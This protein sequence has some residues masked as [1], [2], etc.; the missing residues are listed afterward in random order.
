MKRRMVVLLGVFLMNAAQA[1]VVSIVAAEN[2]YG[3]VAQKLGGPYVQVT[4]ILSNP[5]QDP[6]LFSANPQTAKAIAQA[7]FIVYNGLDYDSWI[8]PLA[9]NSQNNHARLINVAD[10]NQKKTGENPHI[11]YNPKIMAVFADDLSRQLSTSD[12]AH[13][14][15]YQNQLH[16]FVQNYQ[17]LMDRIQM[18]K[19]KYQGISII[20]TE[21]VFNE[22][23]QLMGLQM[24]GQDF[25]L[26]IMNDTEPSVSSIKNFESQITQH[27]V[28]ALIYNNQVINPHTERM[29]NLAKMKGIPTV[30]VSETEPPGEDYFQWMNSQLDKLD[31]ALAGDQFASHST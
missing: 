26:S 27:R 9:T 3:D 12:S 11:W 22:M 5:R 16:A 6:H 29:R 20:A 30:G 8:L 31:A 21:P 28:R 13:Q 18:L 7:S 1:Q 25:Q 24:Q 19:N 10:L 15:Y 2:F 14:A 17:N 4:S 23:A